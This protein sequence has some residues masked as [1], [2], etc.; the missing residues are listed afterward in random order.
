MKDHYEVVIVGGGPAG[1][2]AALYACMARRSVLVLEKGLL[3][4]QI[5]NAD[6]VENFP[7]FPEGVN[8]ADLAE[9]MQKQAA[10]FGLETRYDEVARII[11]EGKEYVVETGEGKVTA[12]TL[13]LAGGSEHQ[14]LGVPG[15][16][17]YVG[18]GVSYCATCD[19]NF[20]R[21][22]TVAIVGGGNAAVSEAMYLTRFASRV[23][24]IHRRNELR[25]TRVVQERALSDPKITPILETVVEEVRGDQLV[26]ELELRNVI[27]WKHSTLK[28]DGVFVAVGYKPNTEFLKGFV[29]LDAQGQVL[30]GTRLDTN[31]PGVFAAGDI[32]SNSGRQAI[33][34]SGDGAAAALFAEEFLRTR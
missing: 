11:A 20:F 8:G 7:G 10:R 5:V 33:I 9:L 32:R 26:R 4:G 17:G 13:I 15:E 24:L 3:G 14:K 19:A 2:T 27:T 22:K 25:A 31:R 28:V 1:L 16:A 12:S 34:A 6:K 23:F 21:E 30:A 18:K 29:E